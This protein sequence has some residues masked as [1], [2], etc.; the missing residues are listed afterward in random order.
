METITIDNDIKV[1]YTTAK[2]FP[3]GIMEAQ[4]VRLQVMETLVIFNNERL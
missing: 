4:G 1:F 3:E 2:S